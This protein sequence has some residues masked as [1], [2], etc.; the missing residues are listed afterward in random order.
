MSQNYKLSR[1]CNTEGY[2]F[3]Y[4][5]IKESIQENQNPNTISKPIMIGKIGA[6]ELLIIHQYA[7]IM[8]NQFADFSPDVKKEGCLTAGIYPPTKEGFLIFINVYLEAIKSM[9]IMAS[10]NDNI[11]Q[12]EEYVW[13]NIIINS[14]T[15]YVRIILYRTSILVAKFI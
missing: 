13:N 11:L 6:N 9:N 12:I 8:Q 5:S 14:K 4:D 15:Y 10:W 2:K 1:K 3:L 7:Y